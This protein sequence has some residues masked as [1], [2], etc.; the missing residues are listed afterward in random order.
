MTGSG[1]VPARA[2]PFAAVPL[3][4]RAAQWDGSS[5]HA[6]A[7]NTEMN[8]LGREFDFE[9]VSAHHR[10]RRR[11]QGREV[12]GDPPQLAFAVKRADGETFEVE[13]TAGQ[14]I[15][16]FVRHGRLVALIAFEEID[17]L[18]MFGESHPTLV[19]SEQK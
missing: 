18:D 11:V 15:A 14:W 13:I 9:V 4:A 19:L 5:A 16:V 1:N 17:G 8:V 7:I 10:G 3:H 6:E 2:V 12:F